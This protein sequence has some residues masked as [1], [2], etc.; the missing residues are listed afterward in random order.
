MNLVNSYKLLDNQNKTIKIV[1]QDYN[2][3]NQSNVFTEYI[4]IQYNNSLY[5][6]YNY[7]TSFGD[8]NCSCKEVKNIYSIFTN[9]EEENSNPVLIKD[10]VCVGHTLAGEYINQFNFNFPNIISIEEIKFNEKY[11]KLIQ[12]GTYERTYKQ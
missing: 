12:G 2:I 4:V 10:Y 8:C 5:I 6:A 9:E 1:S 3:F 11:L 7:T